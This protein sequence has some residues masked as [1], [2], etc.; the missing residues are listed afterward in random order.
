MSFEHDFTCPLPNGLHARPASQLA[1]AALAFECEITL[2]NLRSGAVANA[3]SVLALVAADIRNGDPCRLH[4][5]GT[6]AAAALSSLRGFVEDVLPGCD[7]G[8]SC[9]P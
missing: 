9:G 2:T 8:L 7:E 3:K 1:E 6:G 5:A 4:T